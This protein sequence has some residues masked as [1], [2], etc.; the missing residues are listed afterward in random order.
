MW[1][2]YFVAKRFYPQHLKKRRRRLV[3]AVLGFVA[4]ALLAGG[5]GL[6]RREAS[7]ISWKTYAN[8]ELGVRL[9]Y[10]ETFGEEVLSEQYQKADIVFRIKRE[11]PSAFFSLRYEGELGIMKAFGGGDILDQLIIAIERR[12]P[13]NFPD[14]RKDNYREITL[15]GE[16]A[17]Q[18]DFTY[19]GADGETRVKQRLVLVVKDETVYYL[20]CQSPEEGFF[21]SEKEFD[22]MI[23]S[24]QFL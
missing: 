22:R 21:K 17:A 6:Y 13:A 5:L 18:F 10:P 24:F 4:L 9:T 14:Y 19:T 8:E 23:E 7:K 3:A 15:A 12:Y 11:D 20:S 2:Y 16:K 1:Y